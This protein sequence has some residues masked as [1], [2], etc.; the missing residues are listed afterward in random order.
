MRGYVNM[1]NNKLKRHKPQML[2]R[3]MTQFWSRDKVMALGV[4]ALLSV[5]GV[6]LMSATSAMA[7]NSSIGTAIT[8]DDVLG[9]GAYQVGEVQQ[10]SGG[11]S[12]NSGNGW[13]DVHE[14]NPVGGDGWYDVHETPN[15]NSN[16]GWYDVHEKPTNSNGWYDVTERPTNGNDGWYDVH[17]KP[18]N[19]N[20]GWYDITE[21]NP[22]S[23]VGDGPA[24]KDDDVADLIPPAIKDDDDSA[25]L[26]PPAI[27]DDNDVADLIPPAIKDNDDDSSGL[28]P[29]AIKDDDDVADLIPPAIKDDED[30]A[31]SSAPGLIP[32]ATLPDDSS[33]SGGDASSGGSAG[34]SS[35]SGG[36]SASTP[37]TP[38]GDEKPS[39]DA[40][41]A[42]G[43]EQ[44]KPSFKFVDGESGERDDFTWD[45]TAHGDATI[46][47]FHWRFDGGAWQ[48]CDYA[49]AADE[50]EI[51]SYALVMEAYVTD[52]DGNDSEHVFWDIIEHMQVSSFRND[53]VDVSG[54]LSGVDTSDA[55]GEAADDATDDDKGDANNGKLNSVRD[56]TGE[57][58]DDVTTTTEVVDGSDSDDVRSDMPDTD[59]ASDDSGNSSDG[60]GV[61]SD[62][63]TSGAYIDDADGSSTASDDSSTRTYGTAY[64]DGDD[65]SG[66]SGDATDAGGAYETGASSYE[67]DS[68]PLV[69]TGVSAMV[70]VPVLSG[71]AVV[72]AAIG[73][74]FRNMR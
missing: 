4:A 11:G 10:P 8:R 32:P 63:A 29:P 15:G 33:S 64:V 53:T 26:I 5:G 48:Q 55:N 12:S 68:N 25:G 61:G 65:S 50:V 56:M 20:D 27:K 7:A 49:D 6:V 39:G 2:S 51:P 59:D 73:R 69:Q 30:D 21:N 18:T 72:V 37:S 13:Y 43:N 16:D 62:T 24:I 70:G 36:G 66:Y 3:R 19:S 28:I 42:D 54:D 45:A 23:S 67:V 38:S 17:E 9:D 58:G 52:S 71:I 47:T 14:K 57:Y 34:G 41:D 1:G 46:V 35:S 44:Q 60:N 40:G 74:K 31:S 22:P